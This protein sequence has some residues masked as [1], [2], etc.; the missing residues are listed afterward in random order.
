MLVVSSFLCNL[1]LQLNLIFLNYYSLSILIY[2]Y[3][4][5]VYILI[6][7]HISP[8]LIINIINIII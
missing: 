5:K 3:F 1:H 8:Y 6:V 4:K 7:S 2:I